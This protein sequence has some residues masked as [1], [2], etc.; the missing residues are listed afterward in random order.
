M[1]SRL[2][3]V[4]PPLLADVQAA[5][6]RRGGGRGARSSRDPTPGGHGRNPTPQGPEIAGLIGEIQLL[7]GYRRDLGSTVARYIDVRVIAATDVRLEAAVAA[8][9]FR[10]PLYHRLAGYAVRLPAL[11]EHRHEPTAPPEPAASSCRPQTGSDLAYGTAPNFAVDTRLPLP[12]RV[13]PG[14]GVGAGPSEAGRGGCRSFSG[15]VRHVTSRTLSRSHGATR[16]TAGFRGSVAFRAGFGIWH[17]ACLS[18]VNE[19]SP[20]PCPACMERST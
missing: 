1:P 14:S 10:A 5:E 18:L 9:R 13:M 6:A 2:D 15:A 7:V 8:G 17:G 20:A 19:L 12:P 4:K 16:R 3:A 11:R